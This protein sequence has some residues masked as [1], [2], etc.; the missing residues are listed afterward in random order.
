MPRKNTKRSIPT[1]VEALDSL[2]KR[3]MTVL[4]Y[5]EKDVIFKNPISAVKSLKVQISS[6][7][8]LDQKSMSILHNLHT[9]TRLA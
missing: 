5:P 9:R 7:E 2:I 6:I 3:P 1:V 4:E 8:A